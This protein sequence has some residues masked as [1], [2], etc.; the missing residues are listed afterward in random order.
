MTMEFLT[1]KQMTKYAP[2]RAQEFGYITGF[3]HSLWAAGQAAA[4][5]PAAVDLKAVI[6]AAFL[7]NATRSCCSKRYCTVPQE[8]ADDV[9]AP[10]PASERVAAMQDAVR[11][12]ARTCYWLSGET[13]DLMDVFLR[14]LL[15]GL[16]HVLDRVV[17]RDRLRRVDDTFARLD[18]FFQGLVD[19]RRRSTP[20][21]P[22]TTTPAADMLDALLAWRGEQ[23]QPLSDVTI[24]GGFQFAMIGLT[25]SL[26]TSAE[27]AMAELLTHRDVLATVHAE[28]DAVVGRHR[29]IQESDLPSLPLFRAVLKESW[30]LHPAAPLGAPHSNPAPA[31]V[32]GARVP[33]HSNVLVNLYAIGRDP[34]AWAPDPDAFRPQRFLDPASPASQRRVEANGQHMELLVFG[35][36]KR[37]CLGIKLAPRLQGLLLARLLHAFDWRLVSDVQMRTVPAGPAHRLADGLVAVPEPRLPAHL[38]GGGAEEPVVVERVRAAGGTGG[39]MSSWDVL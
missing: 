3:L 18:A 8:A 7:N 38:Y 25:E 17:N 35:A 20:A 10:A 13:A 39:V 19:A 24:K 32:A 9:T 36:G 29:T 30:R 22:T 31:V 26:G 6:A 34:A 21:T 33:A 37:Q 4:G 16:G 11:E 28:M 1:E 12:W 2:I 5:A 27:W 15:P 23:G 14:D